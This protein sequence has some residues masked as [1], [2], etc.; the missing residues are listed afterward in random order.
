MSELMSWAY[1]SRVIEGPNQHLQALLRAGRDADEIARGVRTRASW[2]GGLAGATEA[3]YA[4]ADPETDLSQ[5]A[6]LG[7]QLITPDS[8][9]WPKEAIAASFSS[10]SAIDEG[11]CPPHALWVQGEQNLPMLFAQSVGMVGTRAASDYGRAVT[12]DFVRGLAKHNYTVVSGGAHGIDTAAHEAALANNVPTV[13]VAAFG[14]GV[15]YPAPNAELFRDVVAQGGTLMSEYPWGVTPDRHRFLTRNRLIA[16]FSLGTVVVEAG[17][18]SGALNTLKWLH[19]L[20]RQA[21]AVPGK[22]TAQESVGTNLAIQDER[23]RMVLN[24]DQVHELLSAV[25]EVDPQLSFEDMFKPSVLQ[26][27]SRNELQVYDSLPRACDGA[28]RAEDVAEVAGMSVGLTVH[29]LLELHR[30][31][32]VTREQL[33]WRRVELE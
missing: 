16:A 26:Q 33:L 4:R 10:P 14:P 11:A 1:L 30:R 20:G 18:R 27:L 21:M 25:G 31:Q 23:A 7:F 22:V 2:L 9:Y 17:F 28:R 12:A 6:E 32:L 5:A 29:L 24:A 3:R 15:T 13:I 8:A 19:I